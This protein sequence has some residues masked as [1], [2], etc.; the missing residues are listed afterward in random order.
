MRAINPETGQPS[1]IA[2]N[3]ETG[4]KYVPPAPKVPSA[5]QQQQQQP[6]GLEDRKSVV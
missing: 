6:S 2:T 5:T 3:P 1:G 4:E